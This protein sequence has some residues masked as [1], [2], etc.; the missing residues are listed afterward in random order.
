MIVMEWLAAEDEAVSSLL[1]ERQM[2][3]ECRAGLRIERT[4]QGMRAACRAARAKAGGEARLGLVPTMG[5]L[6]EGHLSL[7]RAAKRDC[8]VVAVSIFVNPTQF[9]AGEDLDKYPRMLEA[10]CAL[11]EREGVDLLFAPS[12]EEMYPAATGTWVDVPDV[13]A[14]LDGKSRPTHFRGVATVVAKLFNIVDPDVAFFGQKDGAQVAVL[15]AMVRDMN[16]PLELAVCPT[17]RE[18][19]GLAMSSRNRYLRAEERKDALALS[20][21]LLEVHCLVAGGELRPAKLCRVL[22]ES[23]ASAPG[24]R[25]EYAEVVDPGT[26]L[27]VEDLSRGALVAVAAW[28]GDTRLIDNLLL[29]AFDAEISR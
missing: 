15:R 23:V 10:D 2:R 17:V 12:P 18:A 21:A 4:I 6:H 7:I 25:L 5:A 22:W 28:V 1:D 16:F 29:P 13:G 26:L 27:P 24:V 8:D 14:R 9:A 11:L 20:R 3:K 19:D